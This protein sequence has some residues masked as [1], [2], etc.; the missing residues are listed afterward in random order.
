[1]KKEFLVE[2]LNL[3]LLTQWL[4]SNKE[5]KTGKEFTISDTQSYIKRGKLPLYLGC[6][7]IVLD[8]SIKGV[9]LYN[10]EK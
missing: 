7:R 2:K 5:K 9:K 1:M 8:K 4:N 10:I 3:T 6:N